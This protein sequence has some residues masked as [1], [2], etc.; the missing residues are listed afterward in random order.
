MNFFLLIAR[1]MDH[2]IPDPAPYIKIAEYLG[3]QEVTPLE[4]IE[5]LQE[6]GV[7]QNTHIGNEH[8]TLLLGRIC[9]KLMRREIECSYFV[10]ALDTHL[11]V[12]GQKVRVLEDIQHL[13]DGDV[14]H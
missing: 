13:I 10:N 6:I 2:D 4:I 3:E 12:E 7:S 9:D 8:M 14:R 11:H 5:R 1:G